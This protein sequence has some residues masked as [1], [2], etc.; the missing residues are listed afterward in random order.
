MFSYLKKQDIQTNNR[1]VEDFLIREELDEK[2]LSR[3]V[4]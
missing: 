4:L 2:K 3:P 1:E